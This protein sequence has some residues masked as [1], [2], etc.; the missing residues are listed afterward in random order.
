MVSPYASPAGGPERKKTRLKPPWH[1]FL[2]ALV[3]A[4]VAG[5]LA[6]RLLGPVAKS[7][8]GAG[9]FAVGE[10]PADFRA[11][12]L[13]GRELE[14]RQLRGKV[15]VLDFWATWCGPCMSEMPKVIAAHSRFAGNGDVAMIGVSLDT[16]RKQLEKTVA[17]RGIGWPQ[18]FDQERPQPIA[19]LFGVNAIPYSLVIGRDGRVFA[20]DVAGGDLAAAID[21]ALAG[22][23][24]P[25]PISR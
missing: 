3:V 23:A 9:R 1:P 10:M 19:D 14:L 6:G 21:R 5:T 20:R 18:V 15:V 13:D 17:E 25:A 11:A 2:L 22:T 7:L 8:I 24:P 4:V 16:D 12:A